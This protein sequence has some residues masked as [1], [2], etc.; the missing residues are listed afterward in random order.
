VDSDCLR[1]SHGFGLLPIGSEESF[2]DDPLA[3]ALALAR[4]GG[5]RGVGFWFIC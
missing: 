2:V 5:E 1:A 4:E 3:R